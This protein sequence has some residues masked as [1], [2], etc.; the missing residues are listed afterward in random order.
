MKH[1]NFNFKHFT[2]SM[3]LLLWVA[4]LGTAF[5]QRGEFSGYGRGGGHLWSSLFSGLL[6]LLLLVLLVLGIVYLVQLLRARGTFAGFRA[7]SPAV[8]PDSGRGLDSAL[9]IL[10]ERLAKGEIDVEEFEAKRRVLSGKAT[11]ETPAG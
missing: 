1:F 7:S 2:L 6:S 4:G 8:Q 11:P 9:N 10:R 5:A 3:A